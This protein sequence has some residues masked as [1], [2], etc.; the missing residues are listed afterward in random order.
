MYVAIWIAVAILLAL[1][2]VFIYLGVELKNTL[3]DNGVLVVPV[4]PSNQPTSE[5]SKFYFPTSHPTSSFPTSRPTAPTFSPTTVLPTVSPTVSP[6][7]EPTFQPTL[8]PSYSFAPSASPTTSQPSTTV[9]TQN[10]TINNVLRARGAWTYY[11]IY[12]KCCP[13]Y[14]NYDPYYP[15]TECIY[16]NGCRHPGSLAAIGY[17]SVSYVER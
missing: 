8:A 10:P 17:R 5:P 14:P 3:D 1:S 4:Y 6:S 16:Y 11:N 9:P 12:P 15:T 7:C 13:G 2:G